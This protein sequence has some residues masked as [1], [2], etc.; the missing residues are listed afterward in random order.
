M[1]SFNIPCTNHCI[2]LSSTLVCL[3]A[4]ISA[5]VLLVSH[6]G[7]TIFQAS[8][9]VSLFNHHSRSLFLNFSTH[10]AEYLS[11]C[12]RET[13]GFQWTALAF[14]LP[15]ALFL[16]ALCAF[17]AQD[18]V[19]LFVATNVYVATGLITAML[20]LGLCSRAISIPWPSS[21]GCSVTAIRDLFPRF[22]ASDNTHDL[23][24]SPV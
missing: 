6:H 23:E 10:Q 2:A 3:S 4:V 19:W 9:A 20:V 5:V 14:S 12:R 1:L 7:A 8:D 22:N 16:W 18:F 15:K 17:A 13:S 24:S 21:E 11:E